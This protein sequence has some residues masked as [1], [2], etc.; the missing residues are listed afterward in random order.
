MSSSNRDHT[1]LESERWVRG[2]Q[3]AR[4]SA[5]HR[6]FHGPRPWVISLAA[7][8]ALLLLLAWC[9]LPRSMESPWLILSSVPDW[10]HVESPP[11]AIH[12]S[13]DYRPEIG[14]A[15]AAAPR[16]PQFFH[17]PRVPELAITSE[18]ARL[19]TV[20]RSQLP[21]AEQLDPSILIRGDPGLAVDGA[22]G[23]VD[24]IT[25]EIV[26]S[27]EQR[28]TLVVWIF[29]QSG[30]LQRQREDIVKR[31]SRI[32]EELGV[33]E[34]R[35]NAAFAVHSDKPLLAS[36][37]AF[38]ESFSYRT[39][40]PTDDVHAL[41][42]AIEQIDVDNS[43]QERVFSAVYDAAQRFRKYRTS[44]PRRNVMFVAFTDEA[45]NDPESLDAAVRICRNLQIPV[46]VVG[47]PA[48]FGRRQAYVKYIDPDPAF[49]QTPQWVPIDQGPES[50]MPERIRLRFGGGEQQNQPMDSGF[51]PFGLTRLCVETGGIFFA[52]H[53]NRAMDRRVSR[54]ET[55]QWA[56]HLE[57]FFDPTTM[58][59]Y[60]PEY[61]SAARYQAM[62]RE[63][64][65]RAA[66][67]DAARLA[68]ITPPTRVRLRFP[69]RSQS[70]LAQSLSQAQRSAARM[71]PRLREI[72]EILARGLRDRDRLVRPRWQAGFDLAMGR[73]LAVK[74]R[75]EAYN[76]TLALAK[77]G[78]EFEDA[79]SDTWILRPS[80]SVTATSGLE[81]QAAQAREFLQRVVDQHGGTPWELLAR[82]E[83]AAPIGWEWTERHTGVQTARR[84]PPTN[85]VRRNPQDDQPLVLDRPK[86]RRQPPRL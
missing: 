83:L 73:T 29:D 86:P 85:P 34:A 3:M 81:K 32:Y 24:R 37:M 1:T 43:G 42:T 51:G 79:Q 26:L 21:N 46:Y 66:L 22:M 76:A 44:Q 67:V 55:S 48:P 12:Y 27:L 71:E 59:A 58:R 50:L 39:R 23:A 20:A 68:W 54:G 75:M 56:A 69:K 35:G 60:R 64:R 16:A 30:S 2:D 52:V 84:D 10:E 62:L 47:C 38:G 72:H 49:D 13:D 80:D 18:A 77:R 17:E 61:V 45:G 7:H 11:Q 40:H 8:G 28:P 78:M 6:A 15:S 63:N 65:A 53:P 82:R 14:A 5:W 33:I 4:E 31:F 41:T 74:V 36:V 70:E 25:H 9:T 57:R 19:E